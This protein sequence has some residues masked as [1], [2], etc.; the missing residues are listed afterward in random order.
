MPVETPIIQV[1]Y[2]NENR[3]HMRPSPVTGEP[4][5][6]PCCGQLP[7]TGAEECPSLC[8]PIACTAGA[9][10]INVPGACYDSQSIHQRQCECE[11]CICEREAAIEEKP[12]YQHVEGN[13]WR[14]LSK[15]HPDPEIQALRE[16][17]RSS[18]GIKDLL[19]WCPTDESLSCVVRRFR[20]YPVG[21]TG[22]ATVHYGAAQDLDYPRKIIHGVLS[23][24]V[25]PVKKALIIIISIFL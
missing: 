20:Q 15:K 25:T 22:Q 2:P 11:K 7:S 13:A 21:I 6:D 16:K 12:C 9:P 24:E 14:D 17:M 8:C 4:G 19:K 18:S 5:V 10:D 23:D 3:S 1:M